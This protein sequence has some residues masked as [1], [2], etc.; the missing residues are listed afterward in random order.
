MG[1]F[2]LYKVT[3][4]MNFYLLNNYIFELE[5]LYFSLVAAFLVKIPMFL[6]HL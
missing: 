6:V 1:I 3:G 5:I 4:T 2:Y